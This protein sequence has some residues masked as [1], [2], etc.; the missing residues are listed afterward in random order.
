MNIKTIILCVAFLGVISCSKNETLPEENIKNGETVDSTGNKS[1]AYADEYDPISDVGQYIFPEMLTLPEKYW[2]CIYALKSDR[3]DLGKTGETVGLQYHLLCQSIS[4]L[5]N[6]AVDQGKSEAGVW[7]VDQDNRNSY[8]FSLNALKAMGMQEQGKQTGVQLARSQIKDLFDGYVL[9]DVENN[10]E[11]NV[12][13]SVAS[14]VYNAIIVDIR[15]KANY[16]AAGYTM[17]YDA[18][19]KT[20]RDAWSEFKDKCSNKALVMMPVQTGELRDFAIKNNLFVLNVNKQLN[21][22]G[23]GQNLDIFEEVLA[24]LE[25]GAPVF[26]WEQGVSEDLFVN[27][28]SKTGHVWVP[29]DWAYNIPMTSLH[30]KSRQTP[31]LAKVQNPKNIDYSRKKNF[32]SFYLTDG[33]NIQWMMN[34]FVEEF[35]SD[36]N[37]APVKMGF[38]I[39]VGNLAMIA[40]SWFAD[41]ISKQRDECTIVESFG[42]G[43]SYVDNYAIDKN[44]AAQLASLAH[45]VAAQMRQ[46]R[47]KILGLM[48][49]DVQ[50]AEAQRG[51][52]AFVDAN[53]QLEG[54]VAVQY[55]PYAAGRGEIFWMRNK[56]GFNIPVVTIKYSLWNLGNRNDTREGTPKFVANRLISDVTGDSMSFS[57]IAVHAW[58]SFRDVGSTSDE[59]SENTNGNKK[60][61]SA[62]KLCLNH[63][64]DRFEVVS[65]QEL[66]W[67]IRMYYNKL[68]T[69]QYLNEID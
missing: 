25:P 47:V 57:L 48:A 52:Q 66:I 60:G 21:N 1:R 16:D 32:V 45:T 50:S 6:R 54:I 28:A 69:E 38:G 20:T 51:F 55:S 62:A 64:D 5:A 13:A 49:H 41:I 68:Q 36:N 31:A 26:G 63:L 29:S 12:V 18:R 22:S 40:P 37:A 3:N 33:D 8:T 23:A 42:G 44:R 35:Y 58:S 34:R 10:P 39:P 56:N 17:K 15:D 27:R 65:V 59:L 14:H 46:H 24:W 11:S 2:S 43:Y 9:T 4:G 67:R 19:T 7:L 53:D 30:Y 61:A